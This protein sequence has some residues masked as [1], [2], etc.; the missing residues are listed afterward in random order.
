MEEALDNFSGMVSSEHSG[1]VA[2]MTSQQ[3]GQDAQSP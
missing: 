3:L 2:R 1:A